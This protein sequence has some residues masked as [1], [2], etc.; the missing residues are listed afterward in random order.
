MD[1]MSLRR[2]VM[3]QMASGAD[4]VKGTFTVPDDTG[5]NYTLNFGK[6]WSKYF[7]IIEATDESKS[8]I[9]NSGLNA[10]KAY[11]FIGLFPRFSINN[12]NASFNGTYARINPSTSA[13]DPINATNVSPL[14]SKIGFTVN[15]LNN[16]QSVLFKGLTYNYYIVEIK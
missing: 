15:S 2:M 13:T 7:F 9:I 8:T 4:F 6:D 1:M 12:V 3:A 10:S 11:A 16:G 5:A 14:V